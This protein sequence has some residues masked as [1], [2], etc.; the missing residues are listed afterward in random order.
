MKNKR[1]LTL[2]AFFTGI[3]FAVYGMHIAEGYLPPLW[4]LFYYVVCI[5]FA[6]IGLK[7]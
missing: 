2:I 3:P 7:K 1:V 6:F 5:P 4:A